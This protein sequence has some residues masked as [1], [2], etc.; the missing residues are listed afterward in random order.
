[1]ELCGHIVKCWDHLRRPCVREKGHVDNGNLNCHNPFSNSA[2]PNEELIVIR[3]P[4]M[5]AKP[6]V[7]AQERELVSA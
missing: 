7:R 6:Q 1:M 5:F 3:K 4:A 2:P